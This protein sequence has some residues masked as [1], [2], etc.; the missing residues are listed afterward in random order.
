MSNLRR[1]IALSDHPAARLARKVYW[2]ARGMTL[3]APRI[4][5]KPML[6]TF[7]AI[8]SVYYFVMRVFVCEPLFKA[9]CKRYGR[10]LHT[11]V[12][13]HWVQGKGDIVIGDNVL[14]DGKCSF[15]FA[16]RFSEAPTLTIGD[17]TAIG[18]GCS[19]SVGKRIDIGRNCHIASG[20]WMFDS[21][22]HPADPESRLA[23][24]PP[25]DDDVRPI[26]IGDNVWIGSRSIIFPGVTI[27]DGSVVSA[28]SVVTNDVPPYTIVAG[29]PARKI[30]SL[31]SGTAVDPAPARS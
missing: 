24:M 9:Y 29:N 22:G 12:F 17:D 30:V 2:G 19:F 15:I 21:S 3:P 25:S 14:I 10:G 5:V 20:I 4:I 1:T 11:D 13:I 31:R 27:G 18:T 6:W 16:A 23:G 7:L 28:A 8:R 26:T